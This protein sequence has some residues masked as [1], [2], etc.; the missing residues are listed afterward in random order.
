MIALTLATFA[1]YIAAMCEQSIIVR[2]TYDTVYQAFI[3]SDGGSTL[4]V[5]CSICLE[6]VHSNDESNNDVAE[7][8]EEGVKL[9]CGHIFHHKC[10]DSWVRTSSLSESSCPNCRTVLIESNE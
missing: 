7:P 4:T 6:D 5:Q 9:N 1:L 3:S 8:E 10:I 2:S